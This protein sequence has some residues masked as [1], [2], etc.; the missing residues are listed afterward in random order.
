MA[1]EIIDSDGLGALS[2]RE[3]AKRLGVNAPSLYHYFDGKEAILLAVAH[4]LIARMPARKPMEAPWREYFVGVM[5]EYRR[6]LAAHPNTIGLMAHLRLASLITDSTF[7]HGTSAMADSGV[8]PELM[9]TITEAAEAFVFGW[10]F[11]RLG[12]TTLPELP[13]NGPARRGLTETNTLSEDA[14][15][16]LACYALTD[17]FITMTDDDKLTRLRRRSARHGTS[18]SPQ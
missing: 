15:F 10:A 17:G 18:A 2:M 3:L 13:A 9:L 14:R 16:E 4:K 11:T 7:E 5:I 1:L 6:V 12:D 8:P